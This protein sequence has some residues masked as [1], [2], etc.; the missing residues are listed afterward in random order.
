VEVVEGKWRPDPEDV[1]GAPPVPSIASATEHFA[2]TKSPARNNRQFDTPYESEEALGEITE[3]LHSRVDNWHGLDFSRFGK[4]RLHGHVRVGKDRQS[5]QELECYLF[6]EMLICVKEK[7]TNQPER[8]DADPNPNKK[9][10]CTL[11]GSIL[12]KKHL[13]QVEHSPDEAILT[14]SLS[15]AELPSFHLQFQ[16]RSQLELWRRALMDIRMDFPTPQRMPDYDQDNSG[17]EDEDYRRPKRISSI[18]SSYGAARSTV[19]APTEYTSSRGGGSESRP[20]GGMHVPLDIV[21]V[22]PVSS[23][24]QGLKIN[25]L[26]DT[27]RFLV[28]NLGE[29]DRMGLVTFGSSGGGVPIVGMT[30]KN[31]RDWSKVLDSIRPVGQKSLRADV[32][33]GANV[34]MDLLMQR[35]SNN[36]LSSILLISDSSTSDAESVDFVVSRAEAAK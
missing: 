33:E 23:S 17:T 4:L 15:V 13:N 14:L 26:R 5:W 11:K 27:L 25:L 7:K 24:M 28:Q 36:P 2:R 29:R 31:W 18:A 9:A 22:I 6:S 35:K 3:D 34:A 30:S 1:R 21:V 32:V 16:N 19:T 8:W 12:I 20:T 10:K